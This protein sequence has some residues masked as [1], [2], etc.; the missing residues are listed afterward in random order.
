MNLYPGPS[1]DVGVTRTPQSPE[2]AAGPQHT[3]PDIRTALAGD[4][5]AAVLEE[6]SREELRILGDLLLSEFNRRAAAPGSDIEPLLIG[7][8]AKIRRFGTERAQ[9]RLLDLLRQDSAELHSQGLSDFTAPVTRLV[10]ATYDND[11][12]PVCWDDSADAWHEGI[13]DTTEVDYVGTPV[14]EA[15]RDYSSYT[16]PVAGARLVVDLV[17]GA[18]E[19]LAPGELLKSDTPVPAKAGGSSPG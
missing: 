16:D 5:V 17:R 14:V 9:E 11:R 2:H 1:I 8:A 18:F 10:F 6:L 3:A 19:V 4:R 12:D 13:A 15:L 7:W